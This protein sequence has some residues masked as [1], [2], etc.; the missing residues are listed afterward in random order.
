MP[1]SRMPFGFGHHFAGKSNDEYNWV[2]A[3][4]H[5]ELGKQPTI[6][7]RSISNMTFQK[8]ER[9]NSPSRALAILALAVWLGC[10]NASAIQ[11]A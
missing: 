2:A 5:S 10:P 9:L 6:I 4:V 1:E 7:H 11:V 3:R 8:F